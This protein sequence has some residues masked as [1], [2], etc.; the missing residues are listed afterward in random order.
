MAAV[1]TIQR[2]SPFAAF[3]ARLIKTGKPRKLALVGT[4]RKMLTALDAIA[5]RRPP[6][7]EEPCRPPHDP[8]ARRLLGSGKASP[9]QGVGVGCPEP[10]ARAF[11][12]RPKLSRRAGG[13]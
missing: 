6:W 1:A 4:M 10:R 8:P 13:W 7:R 9:C 2:R 3:H 5:H 12:G 11:A